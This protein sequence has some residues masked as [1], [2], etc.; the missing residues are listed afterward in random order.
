M[1]V[2]SRVDHN[3][4]CV[5]EAWEKVRDAHGRPVRHYVTY[6]L[7]LPDGEVLRTRISRPVNKATYGAQLWKT[8]LREQ[9]AVGETE[10]WAC[11]NDKQLPDRGQNESASS[12]H[13]L[14]VS[15]VHQLLHVAGVTDLEVRS[16]TL[17]EALTVMQEFWSRPRP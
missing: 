2:G 5:N 9:L 6:E 4:F 12:S 16:M 10:F 13:A 15:L 17:P 7:R 3:Q 1:N 11:V 8:I 14:P